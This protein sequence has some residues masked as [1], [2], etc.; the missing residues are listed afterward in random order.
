MSSGH[1]WTQLWSGQWAPPKP[2]DS[3]HHQTPVGTGHHCT[4]GT[5]GHY[6]EAD[7]SRQCASVVG[8]GHHHAVG[9]IRQEAPGTSRHH[10]TPVGNG[11]QASLLSTRQPYGAQMG[12]GDPNTGG[13]P[14]EYQ[15]AAAGIMCNRHHQAQV[16]FR[17]HWASPGITGDPYLV[18][19]IPARQISRF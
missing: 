1:Q 10:Q 7:T 15:W 14:T 3:R 18:L 2:P 5:T 19:G 17:H 12:I 4:A 9:I 6:Q 16:G 11:H 8:S 13:I